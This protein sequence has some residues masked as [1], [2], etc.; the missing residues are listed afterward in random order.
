MKT[1]N[2]QLASRCCFC[3]KEEESLDHILWKCNYSELIWK[4]LGDMFSFKN[5]QSFEE[6]FNA[7]K[8]KNPA[9]SEIRRISAFIT[10]KELWFQRNKCVHEDE[11]FKDHIIKSKILH[12]TAKCEV[13][14]KKPMWNSIYDLQILKCFGLK[15]RR[16]KSCLVHEICFKLPQQ[17]QLLLCCDGASKGN[18]GLLGYGVI[19]RNA[20]GKVVIAIEGCLGI[21][22]SYFAEIMAILFAGE[23]EIQNGFRCLLFSFDSRATIIDFQSK[24]VPWFAISRWEKICKTVSS[25]EFIHNYR[26]VNFY[27]NDLAKRGARLQGREKQIYT[28][29]P[30]FLIEIENENKKYYRRN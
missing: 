11:A 10:L 22:T 12:F 18:P 25:W 26:E 29:K 9:V 30:P 15:C 6:V 21:A 7:A 2:F 24:R 5:P 14:M 8:Q 17:N 1:R 19:A 4:W 20:Q 13:R 16:I 28:S 23:W 3:K 27:A